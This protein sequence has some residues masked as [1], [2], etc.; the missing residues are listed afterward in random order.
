MNW[1]FLHENLWW[2][3]KNVR[4]HLFIMNAL[5]W[6]N[7]YT[8]QWRDRK[9]RATMFLFG[10]LKWKRLQIENVRF[11]LCS[12]FHT[13]GSITTLFTELWVIK[14]NVLPAQKKQKNEN[15]TTHKFNFR[16][17]LCG[18]VFAWFLVSIKVFGQLHDVHRLTRAN[19]HLFIYE[20]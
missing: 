5:I 3:R 11:L 17:F 16:W 10:K 20:K 14:S 2:W 4:F 6:Q 18:F 13:F 19:K 12:L 15:K 7:Y 8:A 1:I 9:N